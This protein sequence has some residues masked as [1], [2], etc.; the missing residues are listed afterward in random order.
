MFYTSSTTCVVK[1]KPVESVNKHLSKKLVEIGFKQRQYDECLYTK[2]TCIYVLYI[3]DSI[4]TGPDS[5]ELDQIEADQKESK[6]MQL[7]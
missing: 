6:G 7:H 2:G 5:N 1:S 3:D 4:L